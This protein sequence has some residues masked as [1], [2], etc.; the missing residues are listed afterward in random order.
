MVK[1]NPNEKNELMLGVYG[2]IYSKIG[3]RLRFLVAKYEERYGLLG[4]RV[5]KNE[6][7]REA[8]IRE[9]EEE[10]GIKKEQIL[11]LNLTKEVNSFASNRLNGI[12]KHHF[13]ICEVDV[14][15]NP[16]KKDVN[17]EWL[18]ESAMAKLTKWEGTQ[19]II[20]NL[21]S[22]IKKK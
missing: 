22:I 11:K 7:L 17:F 15:A 4:G 13:F 8:F 19:K 1:K 6:E 21:V 12:E 10:V 16:I 3:Q 18:S 20:N 14:K 5:D 2:V 9:L